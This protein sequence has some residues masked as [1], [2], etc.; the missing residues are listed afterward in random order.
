MA[1]LVLVIIMLGVKLGWEVAANN[2]MEET[3]ATIELQAEEAKKK[4]KYV[5]KRAEEEKKDADNKYKE[6]VASLESYI[7]RLHNSSTNLLS[8][9]A[10]VARSSKELTF[11]RDK[12]AEALRVYEGR[13]TELLAEGDHCQIK[14]NQ[15]NDWWG[16]IKLLYEQ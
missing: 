11:E 2:R 10:G 3:L 14:L 5:E 7:N 6:S 9:A 1:A 8:K 4:V 12:L 13:I 15:F 16:D